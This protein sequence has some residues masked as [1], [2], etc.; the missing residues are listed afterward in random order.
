MTLKKHL[1]LALASLTLMGSVSAQ[2]YVTPGNRERGPVRPQPLPPERYPEPPGRPGQGGYTEQ[3]S[4]ILNRR[5][6]NEVLPL[7]QMMGIDARYD[8]Y[9]VESVMVDVRGSTQNSSIDLLIN[10]YIEQQVG[11]PRGR[12]TLYPRNNMVLGRDIRALQLGIRAL[13]DVDAVYVTLR[14]GRGGGGYEREIPVTVGV[15][16]RLTGNDRLD[17]GSY[18]NLNSYRGYRIQAIE[19]YAN[20]AYN[21]SFLDLVINGF[22]QGRTLEFG[23]YAQTMVVNPTNAVIGQGA[24]SIV[25]YSRGD[26]D[27]H[28]VTLRL[29][30]R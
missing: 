28:Q 14:S 9:T 21:A 2:A 27:V 6:T 20:A 22:N 16:R 12:I 24:E 29:I 11:F 8:N 15:T 5:V 1:M 13:V 19:V 30:G 26:M 18:I 4:I 10:G 17:I 25:F 23:R 3:K 7:R